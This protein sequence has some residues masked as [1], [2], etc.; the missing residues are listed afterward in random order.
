MVLWVRRTLWPKKLLPRSKEKWNSTAEIKILARVKSTNKNKTTTGF[1]GVASG[2]E[3]AC[4]AGDPP[5]GS[6]GGGRSSP[7]QYSCLGE[8]HE[9]KS[10]A[11]YSP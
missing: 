4:N 7:L 8:S 9:Q 10:L 2:K 1:E 6:L 5:V 11:G 3:S